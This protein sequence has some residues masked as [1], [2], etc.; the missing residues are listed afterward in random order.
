MKG[1]QLSNYPCPYAIG[2]GGV[3]EWA[4]E[5]QTD[6]DACFLR[7]ACAALPIYRAH[8]ALLSAVLGD[9]TGEEAAL[10]YRATAEHYRREMLWE[11]ADRYNALADVV[12]AL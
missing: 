12:E 8:I 4:Q 1:D 11:R 6:D 10:I 3:K 7:H 5:C 9:M 2:N